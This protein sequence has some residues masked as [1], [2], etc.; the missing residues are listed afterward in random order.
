MLQY[1]INSPP[2]LISKCKKSQNPK[3]QNPK[4][5]KDLGFKRFRFQICE[6]LLPVESLLGLQTHCKW[7]QQA[8]AQER[9]PRT[10]FHSQ[11]LSIKKI[12]YVCVTE[13]FPDWECGIC[14]LHTFPTF[15]LDVGCGLAR[16]AAYIHREDE[17]NVG[18]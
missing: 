15:V 14:A 2:Y 3:S 9:N 1:N 12:S 17:K 8:A 5:Q 6:I 18:K 7:L 10:E 4:S 16:Q 13:W 11:Y